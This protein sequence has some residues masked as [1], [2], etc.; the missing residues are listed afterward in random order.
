[1]YLTL[2]NDTNVEKKY[3]LSQLTTSRV[4]KRNDKKN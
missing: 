3:V 4:L 2:R 1:M